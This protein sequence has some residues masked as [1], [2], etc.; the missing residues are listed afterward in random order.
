M[1][2]A[3]CSVSKLYIKTRK[4]HD[5]SQQ[6]KFLSSVCLEIQND[7]IQTIRCC[8]R[9]LHL[10]S[11]CKA[12]NESGMDSAVLKNKTN[13]FWFETFVCV[14]CVSYGWTVFLNL[15]FLRIPFDHNFYVLSDKCG[16]AGW[17]S[18]VQKVFPIRWVS[19]FYNFSN[20]NS[21]YRQFPMGHPQKATGDL[22]LYSHYHKPIG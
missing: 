4:L 2:A 13:V 12:N 1:N 21:L 18:F 6:P 22:H 3:C 9:Q 15:K 11:A 10:H 16:C 7:T 5:D 20:D 19:L 17:E 14:T 8:R